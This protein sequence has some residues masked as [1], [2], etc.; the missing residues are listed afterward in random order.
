MEGKM[1]IID[2][3]DPA[4]HPRK[5]LVCFECNAPVHGDDGAIILSGGYHAGEPDLFLCSQ[6]ARQSDL[7]ILG[8]IIGDAIVSDYDANW[9]FIQNEVD[10]I[11]DRLKASVFRAIVHQQQLKLRKK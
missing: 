11:L 4:W 5:K 9:G 10:K 8:Y 3:K 6:C 1:A 7:N 2:T